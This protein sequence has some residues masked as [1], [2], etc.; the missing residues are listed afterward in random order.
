MRD[1]AVEP[2]KLEPG[3]RHA[4][5]GKRAAGRHCQR[6]QRSPRHVAAYARGHLRRPARR[7]IQGAGRPRRAARDRRHRAESVEVHGRVRP[8]FALIAAPAASGA[9]ADPRLAVERALRRRRSVAALCAAGRRGRG[10]ADARARL[11]RVVRRHR[12]CRRPRAPA[13][14]R[15]RL[16]RLADA[17]DAQGVAWVHPA[18]PGR[19]RSPDCAGCA[20]RRGAGHPDRRPRSARQREA[21]ARS[22]ERAARALPGL[23]SGWC[24]STSST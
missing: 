10:S 1:I 17:F 13:N 6:G 3:D 20:R 15:E 14:R 19:Q 7:R 8:A 9:A 16:V 11:G 2:V 24:R 5:R 12:T 22:A 18:R 23:R 4:G 21:G